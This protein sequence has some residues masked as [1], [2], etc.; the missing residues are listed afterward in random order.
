MSQD[1]PGSPSTAFTPHTPSKLTF[2]FLMSEFYDSKYMKSDL[3]DMKPIGDRTRFP[4]EKNN[5]PTSSQDAD[6]S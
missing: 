4:R 3:L 1:R 5:A 6:I 2:R